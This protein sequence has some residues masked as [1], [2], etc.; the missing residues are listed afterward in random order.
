[1]LVNIVPR[2]CSSRASPDGRARTGPADD[3]VRHPEVVAGV[4]PA[5]AARRYDG[6]VY[7]SVA[8]ARATTGSTPRCC[9]SRRCGQGRRG[10]G[11][12]GRCAQV[13]CLAEH[14]P[15]H[16]VMEI[17][18]PP[19]RPRAQ[20]LGPN[21]AGLVVPGEASSASCRGSPANIFQPGRIGVISR[22]GSLGT[23]IR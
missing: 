5:R 7:D 1:M 9:S 22:S 11:E 13:V 4:S 17:L 21:T 15:I 23:L 18:A 8:E 12:P 3:R 16:D 6:P 19:R 20:V 10:R 14:I 2:T